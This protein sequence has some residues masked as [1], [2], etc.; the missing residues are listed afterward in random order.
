MTAFHWAVL[1]RRK[2]TFARYRRSTACQMLLRWTRVKTVSKIPS[3]HHR[4]RQ[5]LKDSC[6]SLH[7]CDCQANR[8]PLNFLLRGVTDCYWQLQRHHRQWLS[9]DLL[10][11]VTT[12]INCSVKIFILALRYIHQAIRW[13][14]QYSV[15]DVT[16]SVRGSRLLARISVFS[17]F[18]SSLSFAQD[19]ALPFYVII[20]CYSLV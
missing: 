13:R 19:F 15:V 9:A 1:Q 4:I 8:A 17:D 2:R 18:S 10:V 14:I 7:G 11:H 20:R 12:F 16:E 6:W 3:D 5:G